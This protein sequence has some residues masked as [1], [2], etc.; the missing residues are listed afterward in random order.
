MLLKVSP[1]KD[2]VRFGKKGKLASR[3]VGPFEILKRIGSVA[4]RLRFPQE[5]NGIHDTFH[6]SNLKKCFAD[7]SLHVPLEE[8]KIDKTLRLV[9]QLVEII[10]REI[11]KL[12]RS[13]TAIVKLAKFRDEISFSKGECDNR[14]LA[15]AFGDNSFGETSSPNEFSK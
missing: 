11:K 2:A 15:S 13:R 1:W 9:E 5:L 8:V 3:Y 4:Y 7:A 14:D 12:K 10:D 6:V